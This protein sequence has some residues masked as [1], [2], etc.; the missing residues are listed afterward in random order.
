MVF[1]PRND[2]VNAYKHSPPIALGVKNNTTFD[3][4]VSQLIF[5]GEYLVGLQAAKVVKEVS[6][7]ALVK[8]EDQTKESVA[9]T[10]YLVLVLEE[11]ARVLKESLKSTDQTYSEMVKMN[12]QGFNEETDVDQMKISRSNITDSYHFN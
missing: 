1:L 3:F 6:E 5:S 8:T 2:V 4:T 9:T 12:Q 11:N 10:Y 7:K